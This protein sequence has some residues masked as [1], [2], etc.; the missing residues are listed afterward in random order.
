MLAEKRDGGWHPK[1]RLADVTDFGRSIDWPRLP[2]ADGGILFTF[3]KFKPDSS[4]T[5]MSYPGHKLE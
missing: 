5:S 2:R 4:V 3:F 1:S